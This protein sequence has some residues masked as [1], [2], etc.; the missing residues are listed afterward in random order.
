MKLKRRYEHKE[1]G[2]NQQL[3]ISNL[4]MEQLVTSLDFVG[5]WGDDKDESHYKVEPDQWMYF[6]RKSA[7]LLLLLLLLLLLEVVLV[8]EYHLGRDEIGRLEE[9]NNLAECW[10]RFLTFRVVEN[11]EDNESVGGPVAEH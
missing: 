6:L 7:V 9:R 10:N 3:P 1:V 2:R 4:Q 5:D 8:G 11:Y